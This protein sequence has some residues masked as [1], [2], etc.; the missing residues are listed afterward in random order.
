MTECR[1]LEETFQYRAHLSYHPLQVMSLETSDWP[2]PV[3]RG[4][5]QV[6]QPVEAA[7]RALGVSSLQLKALYSRQSQE[8]S[9]REFAPPQP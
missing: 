4:Q 2:A 5:N 3:V 6:E 1:S 9:L 8:N 7:P